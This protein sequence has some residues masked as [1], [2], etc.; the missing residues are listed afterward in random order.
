[1][2]KSRPDAARTAHPEIAAIERP[3]P[4][5]TNAPGFG[6]DVVA[7]TLRDLDIPYI[8]LNPGASY[9]G[10]HDSL[11]N[12]LGNAAPQMLLCLHE[13]AAIAIA[14][15]Y[16]KVTGRAMAAAVHSNVGLMHGTMAIFNAWCD[17]MPMM[18]LG[19]T[20]PV[21]AVKRRP[22][23]DWI[24]TA[25]DQGALVR[26]YTKWDDQPASPGAAREGLLRGWWLANAVPQG[27]VYINL[28]AEVQEAKLPDPLPPI[29]IHR[30]IPPVAAGPDP[31]VVAKAVEMLNGAKQPLILAGRVSRSLDAWNNR[32]ALAEALGAGVATNTKVGAAFPTDHPLHVCPPGGHVTEDLIAAIKAADLILSLDWVDLAGTLK[33]CGA[34]VNAKVVQVSL[35]QNLHNGW[36]M[37]HQGLPPV[38]LFIAADTDATVAALVA[39]LP[40]GAS[41]KPALKA[42][43]PAKKPKTSGDQIEVEDL[44][45]HLLEAVGDREVTLTHVSLSWHGAWWHFRHPLDYLGSDGGGGVGGG[46]GI[47]V[48]AA[49]AL[50]GTGRLPIGVCGDGDFLMSCTSLWTAV[51]YRI[52]LLI[53][54]ANNRSFY[55]DEV[56]QERVA[57]MRNR[58][59]ENKWIGQRMGDPEIDLAQMARA[60]GAQGFGPITKVEDLPAAYAKAIAAVEAGGVAV[61]DVRVKPGYGPNVAS[62]MTR[63]TG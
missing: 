14:H 39:A 54:V 57:K 61:I 51:H 31:H 6:S 52:P 2:A 42:V 18:I 33:L 10:L 43:A 55:N 17:R 7:E 36:S 27:P 13:E 22:W 37:D 46:P 50:K 47:S 12:H 49:L 44:A 53:V 32:V 8:A 40:K 20:G 9:R 16:A 28:D 19:A 15:G 25:R 58:P 21:D 11:V 48:G 30:F 45:L 41:K 5:G 60:Q 59:V 24:H 38:D 1:M 23:I 26:H 4:A 62:A 34:G 63:Q 56:H 3:T 35:D 29:D